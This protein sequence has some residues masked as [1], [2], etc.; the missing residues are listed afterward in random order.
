MKFNNIIL[1]ITPESHK[2]QPGLIAKFDHPSITNIAV[3]TFEFDN[4]DRCL[5]QMVRKSSKCE[6]LVT[7]GD[8]AENDTLV[9]LVNIARIMNIEVIHET[10]FSKYVDQ[11]QNN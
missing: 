8:W 7:I 10:N 4:Q 1:V 9:R 11:Q 2:P 3:T 5:R 6:L